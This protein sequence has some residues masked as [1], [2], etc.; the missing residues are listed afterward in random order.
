MSESYD[1]IFSVPIRDISDKTVGRNKNYIVLWHIDPLLGN[2]SE[3]NNE[4]TVVAGQRPA[5][6]SGRTVGSG[7]FYVA[8]SKAI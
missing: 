4:T 8:R 7:V 3:T 6:N 5:R 1:V 2:D